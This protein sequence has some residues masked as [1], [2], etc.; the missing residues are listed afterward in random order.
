[1]N[2]KVLI[3]IVLI[4]FLGAGLFMALFDVKMNARGYDIYIIDK[5]GHKIGAAINYKR[6]FSFKLIGQDRLGEDADERLQKKIRAA[7]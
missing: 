5:K 7:G 2:L 1:M 4:C 6:K 3:I